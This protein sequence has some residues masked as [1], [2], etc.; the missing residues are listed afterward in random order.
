MNASNTLHE[1][2]LPLLIVRKNQTTIAIVRD[3]SLKGCFLPFALAACDIVQVGDKESLEAA[4]DNGMLNTTVVEWPT[5]VKVRVGLCNAIEL[6]HWVMLSRGKACDSGETVIRDFMAT[7]EGLEGLLLWLEGLTLCGPWEMTLASEPV[8][9]GVKVR[10]DFGCLRLPKEGED[11]NERVILA[12]SASE[13]A[14][15]LKGFLSSFFFSGVTCPTAVFWPSQLQHAVNI[16]FSSPK[17]R[18]MEHDALYLPMCSLF[19]VEKRIQNWSAGKGLQASAP[20]ATFRTGES[21]ERHL[22]RD[23]HNFLKG[24]TPVEGGEVCLVSGSYDYYHYLVDGFK[25][26]G[27]GCAYRSLQ[28]ILSWFQY[29]GQML[30]PIPTLRRIQEI[31]SVKD[32]EKMN[33][34]NFVGSKDW[35][36]SFE[37][38]IVLQHFLPGIECTIRRMESGSELD[39]NPDVQRVLRDHFAAKR[40]CPVMI[41]G[42]SY[43]H[44][45]IGIDVNLA[46]MEA[47]YLIADPHYSS[48]ETVVKTVVSKGHVGWKK[49][50]KFFEP[51][52]WYNLCI[53]QVNS[54][55]PR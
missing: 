3:N 19:H 1:E 8:I 46:T 22:T 7:E 17:D 31:L 25:D 14:Q 27:W 49:A 55:D 39:T 47:Q 28:T 12:E 43:A 37:I 33:R 18:V 9:D 52:S 16:R 44:T 2:S 36:G 53:P 50:G 24:Y 32:A 51:N 6:R 26:S 5:V 29:E 10:E 42:S 21:W 30:E 34:K 35:I 38:M 54:F 11:I 20:H 4:R 13:V 15:Y 48:N 45:I 23:V 40:A 41:G